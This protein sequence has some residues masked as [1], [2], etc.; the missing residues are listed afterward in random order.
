M[1]DAFSL[2]VASWRVELDGEDLTAKI[3]PRLISASI[4][5][6]RAEE[7]DQ[8]D[9]VMHDSD[10]LMELPPSGARLTVSMGWE[11]GS[12]LPKG[13]VAKGS[14]KV[15]EAQWQGPPDHITI[16]ARSA[17]FTDAFRVRRD[18]SFV[19]KALSEI[20]GAIAGDNGLALTLDANLGSRVIPA[21]GPGA[22]SDAAL[23]LALGKRFDAVATVKAGRLIFGPV[24]SG[25]STGGKSL[26]IETIER[27][28]TASADYQRIERESYGLVTAVWHD[29][30]SGER[31]T[32]QV[33]GGETGKPKRLRKV[34]ANEAD[35]RQ[36]AQAEDSRIG[37]A[38]ARI[39]LDLP[40]GRPDLF[41]ER[42]ITLTG[43]KSEV[44]ARSWIVEEAEH[45][46]NGSGGLKSRLA[47]QASR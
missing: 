1:A 29:K 33:G 32:V 18:R 20:L 30:A 22:K 24:G 13:L 11:K 9:I 37:R 43:F 41:P 17:D 46:M 4:R 3:N 44:D 23:L 34:Y 10:G 2:P 14:F 7:V 16:R 5:E 42:P 47:L 15:D 8:L 38:K 35:A 12:G 45:S 39:T 21:L 40:L 25:M 27:A 28:A 6:K 19:G 31:K 26:P 36:A